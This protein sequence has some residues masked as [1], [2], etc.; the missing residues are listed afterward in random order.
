VGSYQFHHGQTYALKNF[1]QIG[2]EVFEPQDL[3]ARASVQV[4]KAIRLCPTIVKGGIYIAHSEFTYFA[5]VVIEVPAYG[6]VPMVS[7]RCEYRPSI[8]ASWQMTTQGCM[9]LPTIPGM[10]TI[11]V[12][13]K[14]LLTE[15]NLLQGIDRG[16]GRS[17]RMR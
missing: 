12:F 16:D 2:V 6:S 11:A 7:D 1:I 4:P 5:R 17:A 10:R 8:L 15:S 3:D 13:A 9:M 14:T